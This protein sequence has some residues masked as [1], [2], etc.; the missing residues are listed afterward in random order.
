[1]S[2]TRDWDTT[3]PI[4]HTLV[5]N[6]PTYIR[7]KQVDVSDRLS[8]II[9]GFV[10][11]ETTKGILVLPLIAQ[12]TPT[13]VP[14]QIQIYG[15]TAAGKTELFAQDADA[16]EIQITSV[17]QLANAFRTG[18]ILLSSNTNTP[19]GFTDVSATYA[20]KMIRI[21]STALS[22]G[23]SDTL[24]GTTDS[25][26]LSTSEIPAHT[27]QTVAGQNGGGSNFGSQAWTSGVSQYGS[28]T[29]STGGGGGHTHTLTAIS[30]VNAYVTL[31]AYQKN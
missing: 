7:N 10:S 18:D 26:V 19:T 14:A 5:S 17:G 24:S 15:K 2:F 21:S 22:T 1:M 16:H 3:I 31:K 27:H 6:G 30:C 11:G 12:S 20:N 28:D 13:P 4:D 8:A 9:S 23:G 29:G 25:H